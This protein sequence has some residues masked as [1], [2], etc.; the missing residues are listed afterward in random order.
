MKQMNCW[1]KRRRSFWYHQA[2][3]NVYRKE[4]QKKIMR[5]YDSLYG[6]NVMLHY[7]RA[8]GG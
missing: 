8:R 5:R 3:Q 7:N 4:R 2:R 1:K 6:T